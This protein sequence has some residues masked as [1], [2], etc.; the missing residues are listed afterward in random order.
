[1]EVD[2]EEIKISNNLNS[3]LRVLDKR[4]EKERVIK[5]KA[6]NIEKLKHSTRI[7]MMKININQILHIL[8]HLV[9]EIAEKL[10]N[11]TKIT[12][13]TE[14]EA[15]KNTKIMINKIM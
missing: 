2:Q 14:K 4:L 6:M 15:Q 13:K 11:K 7:L 10:D 9:V 5:N 1:M 3:N 8:K 12:D